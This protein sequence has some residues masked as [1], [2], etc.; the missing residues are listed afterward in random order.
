[1]IR[2]YQTTDA[3]A[4]E[5]LLRAAFSATPHG[6]GNEAELVTKIRQDSHYQAQFEVVA[7]TD[8]GQIVGMGLLSPIK[9]GSVVGQCL[10]P[11]AVLP[12]FQKEGLGTALLTELEKRAAAAQVPFISILGWP[13]YYARFGYVPASRFDITAP[14]DVPDAAF[15][16]K[17]LRPDGLH[18]VH[19]VVQYLRAF[20]EV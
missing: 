9:V 3:A 16:V 1:M 12:A 13:D 11:L 15:R 10:A 19:G 17:A 18:G 20:D 5:Q 8:A 4:V 7:T 2:T 14:Y 6:Y